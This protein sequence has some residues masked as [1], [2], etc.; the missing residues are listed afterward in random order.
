MTRGAITRGGLAPRLLVAIGLVLATAA[1]T[2]WLVAGAI[3]P[4]I[5]HAHLLASQVDDPDAAVEH[6]ELAFRTAS[7]VAL[8]LSLTLGAAAAFAVSVVLTRRIGRSL[9][10]VATAAHRIAQGAVGVRVESPD[11]GAEFTALTDAFNRMA[12]RLDESE[13]LRGRLISDVAHEL[14]TPVATINLALEA[15]EDGVAQL[16]PATVE[17]LRAQGNR[18]VRLSEDL[19]S[20]TRAE[21][22]AL[23]LDVTQTEPGDLLEQALLAARDRAAQ[24]GVDLVLDVEPGL[25]RITV[26]PDRMAQVLGNLVDNAL[27]HTPRDGRVAL[28]AVRGDHPGHVVLSVTDTGTGIAA[29]HLPHVFER[30]YRAD[31]AR[32]RE[33]GGSGVGLAITRALVEAHGGRVSAHS[34]GP[35]EG[36]RFEVTLPVVAPAS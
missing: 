36:A 13:R 34:V 17:V 19:A 32:D 35:G 5:F 30:F 23:T 9:A 33:H 29:E 2:A 6:A 14:R 16:T 11:M 7:A 28:A 15:L 18:L 1:L 4:S 26:D 22:G 3:G 27:R 20:V 12:D 24:A 31:S 25:P 21:S 8:A 10:S